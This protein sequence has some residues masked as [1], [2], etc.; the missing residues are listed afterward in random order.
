[1]PV[2][3]G[4]KTSTD[5]GN[6]VT[7]GTDG[8][9]YAPAIGP[10]G[11]GAPFPY[12]ID[13]SWAAAGQ[14]FSYTQPTNGTTSV[15]IALGSAQ[16]FPLM[17]TRACRISQWMIYVSTA[18]ASGSLYLSTFAADP[19]TGLPAGKIADLSGVSTGAIG[20]SS[21]LVSNTT[22]YSPL[23]LY[24]VAAWPGAAAATTYSRYLSGPANGPMRQTAMPTTAAAFTTATNLAYPDTSVAWGSLIVAPATV[25]PV[26]TVTTSGANTQP[27]MVWWELINA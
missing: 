10:Y 25:A 22:V 7:F 19:A 11:G 26:T 9:L 27:L 23:T 5:A 17:F 1:M 2:V 12:G 3:F 20:A 24:W 13:N 15:A 21:R 8:G 14:A 18:S 16:L 4:A 6:A